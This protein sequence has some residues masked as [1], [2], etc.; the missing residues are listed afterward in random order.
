[1]AH[2]EEVTSRVNVLDMIA[3]EPA[4]LLI[5]QPA[6]RPDGKRRTITQKVRVL[7]AALFS[8]LCATVN[9]GEEIEVTIVTE[10][11]KQGYASHLSDFRVIAR[12]TESPNA[13]LRSAKAS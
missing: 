11:S 3:G 6:A 12:S 2:H 9:K 10:W 1:M 13:P 8:R 5:A 4:S 7:D